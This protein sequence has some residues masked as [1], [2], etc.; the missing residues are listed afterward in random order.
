MRGTVQVGAGER[1]ASSA[2]T[3]GLSHGIG[4]KRQCA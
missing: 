1:G 4:R 2:D 3:A